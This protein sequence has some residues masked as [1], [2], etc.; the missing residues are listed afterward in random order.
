MLFPN[1]MGY[2]A[3]GLQCCPMRDC[4]KLSA[5]LSN[6]TTLRCLS[7]PVCYFFFDFR[8][9][10]HFDVEEVL[11]HN[12][13]WL[14]G[15]PEKLS[16]FHMFV[17][18][19]ANHDARCGVSGPIIISRLRHEMSVRGLG[20][21]VFV[22]PCTHIGGHKYRGNVIMYNRDALGLANGVW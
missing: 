15:R 21:K 20:K 7:P 10:T 11:V 2:K 4:M 1:M 19:H 12:Q 13:E 14:S 16:G 6:C 17:C 8:G 18:A 9:L 3:L 5:F 22:R